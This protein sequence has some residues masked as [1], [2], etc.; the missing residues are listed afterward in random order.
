M[1]RKHQ[2][3]FIVVRPGTDISSL[4]EIVEAAGWSV[5]NRA[6][7]MPGSDAYLAQ[8]KDLL[9]AA[10]VVLAILEKSPDPNTF[11]ELGF[12]LA[13]E[14]PTLLI[15]TG[16]E[17]PSLALNRLPRVNATLRDISVLELHVTAFL[18]SVHQRVDE[19]SKRRAPPSRSAEYV[20]SQFGGNLGSELEQ[21]VLFALRDSPDINLVKTQPRDRRYRKFVP[22]FAIWLDDD[23]NLFGNPIL[24]EVKS[25]WP[26]NQSRQQQ[27]RKIRE[28]A[29]AV[30]VSTIIIVQ[31]LDGPPKPALIDSNPLTYSVSLEDFIDLVSRGRLRDAMRLERNRFFHSAS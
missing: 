22:D 29:A 8:T 15:A 24:I 18:D 27:L 10:D 28:Y 14:R 12:A 6:S 4:T 2:N 20:G 3:C 17:A 23:S 5:L 11:F 16:D 7:V 25:R 21:Q 19:P 1:T 30:D 13:F 26:N 9:K 31:A